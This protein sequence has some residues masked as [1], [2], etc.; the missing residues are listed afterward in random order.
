MAGLGVLITLLGWGLLVYAFVGPRFG[1]GSISFIPGVV[2][3][4]AGRM[5]RATAKRRRGDYDE[6][7]L[8]DLSNAPPPREPAPTP[9]PAPARRSEPPRPAAPTPS[10]E[11]LADDDGDSYAE[12]L[13]A[14]ADD[15]LDE[16][17]RRD[18]VTGLS[19]A[20]MIARA[21]RRWDRRA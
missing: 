13:R 15:V 3:L 6:G 14:A 17:A 20:E 21:R 2:F 5:L 10:T 7:D 8:A 1:L 18:S 16:G 4:I 11:A 9:A 12:A 19:S